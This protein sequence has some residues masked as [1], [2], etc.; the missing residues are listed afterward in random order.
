M[1][2]KSRLLTIGIIAVL[3]LLVFSPQLGA[4]ERS[5][6]VDKLFA[7]WDKKD[8]P[9]CALGII[10]SGEFI[11]R[12]GY[13]SADLEY[14][15]PLTS[16]SV[17]RIGSTSKQF[18][19]MCTLLLEEEGKLSLD[20]DIQLYIPEMPEY[21]VPITFRHLLHHTSG[22]RDY[23]TLL[24]LGGARDDD[25]F[26][27][28]EITALI[29]RQNELN[30][31]PGKEFLYS[32][33]G[34]FLLAEIVK[35]ITG[36]SMRDFAREHIFGPL[37]MKNT[38]FHNDH[39]EIVKNRASGYLPNSS[40][41]FRIAMTNLD[42]IGDGGVFTTV[43]DLLLWDR[44]FYDNHL[45]K[46]DPNLIE[47][48]ISRGRLNSGRHLDYAMGLGL[49]TYR[50]LKMIAHG[51][52]FVGFRAEMIR[53]PEQSFSVIVL[54]NL[55]TVDP[56]S[57][58]RQVADIYLANFM[59]DNAPAKAAELPHFI[60]LGEDK[61]RRMTGVY[62]DARKERVALIIQSQK[63]LAAVR[64]GHPIDFLPV[65]EHRFVSRKAPYRSALQFTEK[66]GSIC[67]EI[68]GTGPEPENY[69]RVPDYFPAEDDLPTG[70]YHSKELAVTYSLVIKDGSL[71]LQHENPFKDSP[72]EELT[73]VEKD[74][75]I[76]PW[77]NIK[78]LR[79]EDG[80]V[81]AF[82]LSAGRVRNIR[83]ERVKADGR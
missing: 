54:A 45:G 47:R 14:D 50:G 58:A 31:L 73:A 16:R 11:Y 79:G 77:W 19:A 44:N 28:G 70:T 52:S 23:L 6:R 68:S 74:W 61:I 65:D 49:Y 24:S 32:N 22:I 25:Y 5:D 13:G 56:S 48:M 81:S 55:G 42:M 51:G 41:G 35:R 9:G 36:K 46:G 80:K 17:F 66:D 59:S 78:F 12:K 76:L 27:D 4:D 34:Y 15:I 39:T 60:A 63:G 30:F 64:G 57:L 1:N 18:T 71:R 29:A 75:F 40:G 82:T 43:D 33:S 7:R 2:D 20:D 53:F 21:E 8:S 67:L 72:R 62:V 3:I 83:F 10:Q 26:V 69:T 37:G 38:H